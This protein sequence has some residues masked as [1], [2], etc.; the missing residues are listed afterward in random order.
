MS[1]LIAIQRR[2]GGPVWTYLMFVFALGW[3]TFA[4]AM[5]SAVV[6]GTG[7]G[8][9]SSLNDWPPEGIQIVA[10]LVGLPITLAVMAWVAFLQIRDF[11]RQHS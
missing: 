11:T 10:T 5:L 4:V 9:V 6:V 1:Q 7:L 2:F 3:K 8:I